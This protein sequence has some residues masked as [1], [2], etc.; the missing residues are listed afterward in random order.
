MHN[1]WDI[2]DEYGEEVGKA[3]GVRNEDWIRGTIETR[4][5]VGTEVLQLD[6]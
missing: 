6:E 2:G 3:I 5:N 1:R 4:K